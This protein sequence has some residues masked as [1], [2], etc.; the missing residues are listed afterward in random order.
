[1]A[2]TCSRR[3]LEVLLRNSIEVSPNYQIIVD[4]VN[5]NDTFDINVELSPKFN[6]DVDAEKRKLETQLQSTLGIKAKV[7]IV[8]FNLSLVFTVHSIDVL[9]YIVYTITL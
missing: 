8:F 3:R 9:G 5:N 6:G 7:H 2:L 4:R 1:M